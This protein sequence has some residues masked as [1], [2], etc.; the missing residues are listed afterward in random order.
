MGVRTVDLRVDV[1]EAA[2]LGEPAHLAVTV[3]APDGEPNGIVAVVKP[4]GGYGRRYFTEDLPGPAQGAQATWHA[5]RGWV[6]LA[7]DHLGVG[8]SSTEHDGDALTFTALTGAAHAAEAELLERLA[9]GELVD[10]LPPVAD[11][12]VLGIGQSMGGALTIVQQGRHHAYD[13]IAVLGYSPLHTEPPTAPGLAPFVMPWVPRDAA[14]SSGIATNGPALVEGGGEP[15]DMAWGFHFDDVPADVVARDLGDFPFRHGDVPPWGSGTVPLAAA[16]WC[17][18]PGSTL[19]EAAG[20]RVPVLL[21]LG[22][23]DVVPDPRGDVRAFGGSPAVDLFICEGMAH[24]HN[25]AGTRERLWQRLH[26]W[27]EWV[28]VSSS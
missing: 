21:A 7:A 3:V 24:M 5:E 8:D 23:R 15:V 1:T 10:G 28:A 9:A 11:P 4:G 14:P 26:A 12:V 16:I 27:G 18:A 13:G 6:V 2:G 22:E 17:L 19:A 20:V 25:F